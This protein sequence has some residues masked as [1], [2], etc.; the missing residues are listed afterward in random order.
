MMLV[1]HLTIN[2][3][4]L[5]RDR[6]SSQLA[7]NDAKNVF[8]DLSV[9]TSFDT[10]GLSLLIELKKSCKNRSKSLCFSNIS[11]DVKNLAEFYDVVDIFN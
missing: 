6:L 9:C 3:V 4:Q 2:T 11:D 7:N 5:L 1:S 8:I 10:A